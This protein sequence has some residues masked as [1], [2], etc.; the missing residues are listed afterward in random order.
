MANLLDLS[1]VVRISLLSALR[2]LPDVNTSALAIITDD[3]P[4][5]SNFGDARQYLNAT[6]VADDFGSGSATARMAESVFSQTPNILTGRGFLQIIP[7][8][9]DASA[10]PATVLSRANVDLTQ[11]DGDDYHI[12]VAVDGD[13]ASDLEIG[14]VDTSSLS[15]AQDSLN[16]TA[17]TGAGLVFSLTGEVT[18]AKV[19]LSTDSDGATSEIE[20]G[21]SETGT[22]IA[23]ILKI[24]GASATGADAGVERPKDTVLRVRDKVPFFGVVLTEKLDDSALTEFASLIQTLDKLFFAPS[25]EFSDVDGVFSDIVESGFTHTRPLLYTESETDAID[26]AAGYA[27]RGLSINFSGENTAHTMH[28]KELIGFTADDLTQ[29]QLTAA[30]NAGVDVYANFGVPKLFTSGANQFFDQVYTRLALVL[31]LRIAL[32]NFLAQTNTK[33]PQTEAGMASLKSVAEDV[34]ERFVTNGTFAPGEWNGPAAFGD[35]EDF[36]RNIREQ[37]YFVFSIPLAQQSQGEREARIAPVIQAAAKDAGAIHS[38]DMT[39]LVEA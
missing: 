26:F 36:K 7:R 8:D 12:N 15:A 20:V 3:E 1:N 24:D 5:P 19:E 34:L 2:G 9:Q 23:P 31:R 29:T 10:Q 28:L 30:N 39:I 13:P 17:V 27:S 33:I 32:F 16:S 6:G 35:P 38:A 11:L 25:H 4:I 22:D 37:G 14:E 21:D 18:S